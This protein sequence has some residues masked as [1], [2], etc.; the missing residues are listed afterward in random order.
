MSLCPKGVKLYLWLSFR[1]KELKAEKRLA[2][3][4]KKAKRNRKKGN[5]LQL[6]DPAMVKEELFGNLI[7]VTIL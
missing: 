1:V 2:A 7:K 4:K 5:T 6:N 3:K